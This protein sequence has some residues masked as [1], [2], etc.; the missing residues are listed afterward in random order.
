MTLGSAAGIL[1]W[2]VWSRKA[3]N[4]NWKT[5][6]NG[7]GRGK[8]ELLDKYGWWIYHTPAITH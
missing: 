6:M 4:S 7:G 2:E 8:N 5:E 3:E 1:R